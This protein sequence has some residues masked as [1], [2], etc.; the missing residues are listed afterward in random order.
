MF[1][2]LRDP[3][4]LPY[5][6]QSEDL[7]LDSNIHATS[8]GTLVWANTIHRIVTQRKGAYHQ[9]GGLFPC[10]LASTL[11]VETDIGEK[12]DKEGAPSARIHSTATPP[13]VHPN[14]RRDAVVTSKQ[15]KTR[16]PRGQ[17]RR[18]RTRHDG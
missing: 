2:A 12:T 15:I 6:S 16:H 14:I 9:H 11:V 1:D 3:T 5:L 4:L 7:E 13:R 8:Y 18:G 17:N 10:M